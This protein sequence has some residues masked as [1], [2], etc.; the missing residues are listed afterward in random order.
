[1]T[2]W[3]KEPHGASLGYSQWSVFCFLLVQ[4]WNG[5]R[6]FWGIMFVGIKQVLWEM[7]T[8]CAIFLYLGVFCFL[9]I[10]KWNGYGCFWGMVF[11][12]LR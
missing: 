12:G 1:M 11:V 7:N 10:Q 8:S 3:G 4:K 9:F 6:F 5:Y 2:P